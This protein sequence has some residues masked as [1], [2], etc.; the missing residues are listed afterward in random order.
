MGARGGKQIE[1]AG[2]FD[3]ECARATLQQEHGLPLHC[4]PREVALA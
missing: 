1:D 4:I 3:L 2:T